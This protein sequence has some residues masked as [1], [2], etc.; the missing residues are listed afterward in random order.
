VKL[1]STKGGFFFTD[2]VGITFSLYPETV[3]YLENYRTS[4]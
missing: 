4:W 2:V 1:A 3:R